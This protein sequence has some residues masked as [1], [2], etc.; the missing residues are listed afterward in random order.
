MRNK[1]LSDKEIISEN[2]SENIS[3]KKILKGNMFKAERALTESILSH[4]H[5]YFFAAVSLIALLIRLYGLNYVG[6][7]M[8]VFLMPWFNEIKAA[9]GF[10]ALAHQTG[11][12]PVLYQTF[13]AAITYLNVPCIYMYKLLS[14]VFDYLLAFACARFICEVLDKKGINTVFNTVYTLVLFLPTVVVNSA[15]WGQCDSIY[16][17]FAVMTLYYLYKDCPKR[18]FLMLG[19]GFAFKL[20]TVFILPFVICLYF[21][22]RNFTILC[23]AGA[24]A[25]FWLSGIAAYLNGASLLCTLDAYI[26]VTGETYWIYNNYPSFWYIFNNSEA[27]KNMTMLTALVLCGLGL[28]TVLTGNKKINTAESYLNTAAWFVW[29]EVM[30]LPF[31]HE[32]YGYITDI[33][34]LCLCFIKP[35]YI[36]YAA[37]SIVLSIIAYGPAILSTPEQPQLFPT[38]LSVFAAA[39]YIFMWIYYTYDIIKTDKNTPL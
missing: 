23:F 4:I 39:T 6:M 36:K 31:M 13:I 34:L 32:R 1:N 11:S 30:F 19:L 8:Y 17:Y 21:A 12:Y 27:F 20:Q 25:V 28:Y 2:I 14:V 38:N 3:E 16:T 9:G 10:A 22:K 35:K 29:T 7:D 15:Y 24:A 5:I 26:H 37:L 33:L 18:G